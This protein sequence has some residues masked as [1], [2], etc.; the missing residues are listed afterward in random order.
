[1][2]KNSAG[3][4]ILI[5]VAAAIIINPFTAS[6][7]QSMQLEEVPAA[8]MTD[9]LYSEI[10]EKSKLYEAVPQDAEIH[11]IWKATP[12]YN[13]VKVDVEASYQRMKQGGI[14]DENLLVFKQIPPKV[15]LKDLPASPIYRGNPEK[16]MVSFLINVA[17]G[18][19]YIP[20]MLDTLDKYHVKATFFLEG[21]WVK[22]NTELAKMISDSGHEV[23]N[24]SYSHPD[25]SRLSSNAI[26]NELQRTNEVI[27][28]ATGK[29]P[30]WF[31]PPSGSY[32]DEVTSAARSLQM[33]MVLWSVDTIDWQKP[34]P[35]VLFARVM[36]KVH[37]GAMILMHPTDATEK[38]LE[39][40]ILSIKKKGLSI[41]TVSSLMNEERLI[42][43]PAVLRKQDQQ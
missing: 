39:K 15:H 37:N 32:R 34:S 22:E 2:K 4:S 40:L 23:G 27:E 7:Y 5:M 17:W 42:R 21:R 10:A 31:G 11:K 1:M 9:S 19:E 29:K 24:H 36:K 13:G 41:G 35:D 30:D 16:P 18:N 14:F 3:F 8:K 25:M 12:G 20:K 6:Y 38:S 43:E 33:G 28:A 26:M